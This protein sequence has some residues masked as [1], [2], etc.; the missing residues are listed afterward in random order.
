[1]LEGSHFQYVTWPRKASMRIVFSKHESSACCN[2][3]QV[4]TCLPSFQ[5]F[6]GGRLLVLPADYAMSQMDGLAAC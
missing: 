5:D 6:M 3:F 1:M 4:L 2:C